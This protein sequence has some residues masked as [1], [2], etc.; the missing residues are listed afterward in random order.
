MLSGLDPDA[1]RALLDQRLGDAPAPE[2]AE[3]L[4]GATGGNPLA[5]LELPTELSEEQLHGTA[6]LPT[7]LHLSARVEQAFLDRSR[8]LPAPVQTLLLVAAADD[9]GRLPV[10][11]GA[12]A[13]LGVAE[14]ALETAMASG[15][16]VA[17]TG[18][19]RGASP[20]GALGDLPGRHRR[21][22]TAYPPGPGGGPGL[23]RG[24][25]PRGV[26]PRRRGRGSRPRRRRGARA[27]RVPCRAARRVRRGAGRLR[28]R[29]R[30]DRTD[31][32]QRAALTL[33]AARNAW[34]CGQPGRARALLAEARGRATDPLLLSGV[35]RLHGRIEVN[36]GS[37][38]D[39]H[40]I[41]VEAAQAIH[42]I[43]PPRALEMAVAAAILRT[44]GAGGATPATGDVDV[45]VDRSAT[46][47]GRCASSRCSS[48]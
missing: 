38:T 13:T 25:R 24:L 1:A 5:L 2:V 48:R 15:L 3:R 40:R 37:A 46:Q 44:Y 12:S 6:P 9:T 42:E 36:L 14:D 47:P 27:G 26:A 22:A 20:P 28:T 4:I 34:A 30:A 18:V 33:A 43:D 10:V 23:A 7:Q 29:G 17:D 8:L 45:D 31:T 21:A 35:A 32:G 39:A 16:L 41:F 19:G 11:R